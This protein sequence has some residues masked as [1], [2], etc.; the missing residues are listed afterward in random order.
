VHEDV[1]VA[2]DHEHAERLWQL[3]H[4][5]PHRLDGLPRLRPDPDRDQRLNAA[6][7]R[8]EVHRGVEAGDHAT[9]TQRAGTFQGGRRGDPESLGELA[10]RLPAI[11]LQPPQD[12]LIHRVHYVL[13][14]TRGHEA[15]HHAS[16]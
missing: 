8:G 9:G 15:E 4:V 6:A 10:V 16:T 7:E 2:G 1:L 11:A 5:V 12:R 13:P 14:F 3:R